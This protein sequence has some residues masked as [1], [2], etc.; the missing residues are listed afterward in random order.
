[1]LIMDTHAQ[2]IRNRLGHMEHMKFVERF[3]QKDARLWERPENDPTIVGAMGWIKIAQTMKERIPELQAFA[4]EIKEAGFE[5]AVLAGMGGSSLA[6]LVLSEVFYREGKGIKVEILDTTDP[7]TVLRIQRGGPLEKTLFI[8]ASKSGT[9]AEPHAFDD[10]FFDEVS[11]IK[12]NP[13]ENFVAITDPGTEM[14]NSARARNFRHIFINFADIGGRFSALSYFGMVPAALMELDLEK[15]LNRAIE[16]CNENEGRPLQEC[17]AFALGTALGTLSTLKIDKCTFWLPKRLE[18]FGLWLEQL[19]AE[20]TGKEGKGILPVA[21]EEPGT[22]S[23]YG[24]DR[25]FAY[26]RPN[27]EDCTY[28]D[29][30]L[31]P[32]RDA[33]KPIVAITINDD[34]DIAREMMR[35]ELATAVAGSVIGINPFD[36]PNVQE[37]KDVTKQYIAQV[38]KEGSLPKIKPDAEADGLQF[39]GAVKGDNLEELIFGF[40]GDVKSG[41]FI[42]LQAYLT[43]SNEMTH[44]LTK[45]QEHL[46]DCTCLATTKGYGPR[47][48]HST[49]QFHKGGPNGGHFIQLTKDDHEDVQLPGRHYTF[50]VF[51]NAQVLGDNATLEKHGRRVI[52]IHLGKDPVSAVM[53]ILKAI[54]ARPTVAHV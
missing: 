39:Y 38:E 53:K 23:E 19:I 48:L 50:G 30:R 31:A 9:T 3:W 15:L 49:G 25:V 5:R 35:W 22:P 21:G 26:L 4:K 46:R 33:G 51:R 1:M 12:L 45:L 24:I 11:K 18:V 20:S 8:I 54:E 14:D 43:E 27:E 44:C 52:R 47:F 28:M 10:Y 41:D 42:T 32:L 13:G 37:S 2:A 29:A 17:P 34:Y 40:L 6:P 36:Q 7:D 16:V